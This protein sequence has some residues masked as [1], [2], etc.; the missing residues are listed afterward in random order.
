[1]QCSISKEARQKSAR[2]AAVP[3][4]EDAAEIGKGKV[5]RAARRPGAKGGGACLSATGG[6]RRNRL[7]SEHDQGLGRLPTLPPG[8]WESTRDMHQVPAPASSPPDGASATTAG[9]AAADLLWLS[10]EIVRLVD[11][12]TDDAVC[13][14]DG[15]GRVILWNASAARLFGW[16]EAEALGRDH[17]MFFADAE[18][19]ARVPDAILASAR[20]AGEV[21]QDGWRVRKDGS[22][23]IGRIV[24]IALVD[25]AGAPAGFAQLVSDITE[26][27]ARNAAIEASA[28]LLRSILATVP[29]AMVVIDEHGLITSFSAAAQKMFDYGEEE[30]VGRNVAMLMLPP[31]S[32]GHDDYIARYLATGERRMIGTARRVI[33]RRKDGSTFPH[34]L[35][36]GEAIGGGKRVFTGFM[37]DLSAEEANDARLR[38]LQA[39]L[40]HISRVGAM[41]TMASTLAH[42]L[43]QPLT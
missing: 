9:D 5:R 19:A 15:N 40:L 38:E 31:D 25:R 17:T 32:G 2:R 21:H 13:A 30:V 14:L 24:V 18:I 28:T 3:P 16:S 20:S 29:D 12:I 42:E 36:V 41:G 23:F 43:N 11:R 34:D 39:E 8:R 6:D 35:A 27:T 22:E 10:G 7:I 33:G 26:Q 1:M 37:R 4:I